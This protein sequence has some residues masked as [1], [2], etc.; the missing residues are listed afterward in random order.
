MAR[1][2]SA[3]GRRASEGV[4]GR[5]CPGRWQRACAVLTTRA[6]RGVWSLA[7]TWRGAHACM[8][9]QRRAVV[10]ACPALAPRDLDRVAHTSAAG[11]MLQWRLSCRACLLLL[12]RGCV[13]RVSAPGPA[14]RASLWL[15]GV[16]G[17]CVCVCV[18]VSQDNRHPCACAVSA[19]AAV[20]PFGVRPSW[21]VLP[22]FDAMCVCAVLIYVDGS[23][24][25]GVCW[26]MAAMCP[27][28]ARGVAGCSCS[29]CCGCSQ[30]VAKYC[31]FDHSFAPLCVW[32]CVCVCVCVHLAPSL[33]WRQRCVWLCQQVSCCVPLGRL[34]L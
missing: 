4:R 16:C 18:C 29:P 25:S 8:P 27:G 28:F 19:L 17:L 1:S 20:A 32:V 12:S 2:G 22:P 24:V 14:V 30:H 26:Q 7:A 11:C 5:R 9:A 31:Q 6:P 23:N 13:P 33:H 10:C 34:W 3:S 21:C 15:C